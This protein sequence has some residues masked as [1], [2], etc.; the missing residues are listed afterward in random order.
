MVF[1]PS[2][3]AEI[4][5]AVADSVRK[6]LKMKV[7]TAFSH[8]I[9]KFACPGSGDGAG[10]LISTQKF[11]REITVDKAAMTVTADSG[12]EL[13]D[14]LDAA[15][16]SGLALAAAPYWEGVSLGG[17]LST[18]SHGTSLWHRGGAVHDYV[19]S[20]RLVIPASQQEGYAKV[21]TLRQGDP[22]LNAAMVSLGV[23]GVISK[24]TLALEPQFKRN[25]TNVVKNDTNLEDEILPF[26]AAHEFG[27][28][29][30]YSSQRRVVHRIDNR[31]PVTTPGNGL[32]DF[33]GFQTVSTAVTA[34]LRATESMLEN[35]KNSDGKCK[36]AKLIIDS[37]LGLANGLKNNGFMFTGYPVVGF[38]NRMQTSG[39][40]YRSSRADLLGTCPW[41]P[42]FKGLFF[43]ETT[44]VFSLAKIKDFISDV[45]KLRDMEPNSFCGM[46]LYNGFLI[47]FLKG[48]SAY[49]GHA[50]CSV[51]ID[52]NYY[53][54]KNGSSPRLKQDVWEEVEQMAFF[55]HGAVPHWAK[56]RNLAFLGAATKYPNLEKFLHVMKKYDPDGLFS[57]DLTDK[58]LLQ[59]GSMGEKADGCALE[60]MCVCEEDR[61]CA[62][63][64][65]YLC[66]AGKVYSEARVCRYQE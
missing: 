8:T 54:A 29:T 42:R 66:Q 34:V 16:A 64:K 33:I 37:K 59:G 28:L 39:S 47:R 43:Y 14:L 2:T 25:V 55:K 49:L 62:P 51:V 22:D 63:S 1:Y 12:V 13:R 10:I 27:D 65:G 56:N 31:V 18:G 46:D 41:D 4:L 44:A 20:M 5:H 45:K 32:N 17:L 57:S 7:V 40:C 58:I 3:E 11:K 36:E 61:H 21:I 19:L 9:P 60:G 35:T 15:A 38:Q 50:N 52:F 53:R 23:L 48:S 30:W 26:A 6:K 24:V